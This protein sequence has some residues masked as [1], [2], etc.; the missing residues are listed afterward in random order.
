M[1]ERLQHI[2]QIYYSDQTKL[3]CWPDF[4]HYHNPTLSPFFEN[5]C[6]YDILESKPH[7][8]DNEWFGVLSPAFGTKARGALGRSVTPYKLD[9]RLHECEGANLDVLGFFRTA[10]N[11]NNIKQGDNWHL[12]GQTPNFSDIFAMII[13]KAGI[14]YNIN[15]RLRKNQNGRPC[16]FMSNFVI[17]RYYLWIQYFRDVLKP[18]MDVMETDEEIK[19]LVWQS[20]K[21]QKDGRRKQIL[22]KHLGVPYHPLHTFICERMWSMFVNKNRHLTFE[23]Y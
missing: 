3:E 6:I 4:T 11:L 9:T 13:D 21:Y 17:A 1:R 14:Q 8:N 19:K 5:K 12:R 16:N 20:A 23:H 18:C 2:R 15:T 10:Q 22:L 7:L